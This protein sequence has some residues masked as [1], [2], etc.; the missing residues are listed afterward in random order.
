MPGEDYRLLENMHGQLLGQW[1]RE[2]GHVANVVGGVELINLYY[3]DAD[4]R[5]FML[6]ADYQRR[7]VAFLLENAFSTPE[8]MMPNDVVLR[9]T[10]DGAA[11]RMLAAQSGLLRQLVNARRI[12]RMAEHAERGGESPYLPAQMLADLREGLF[13]E[14]AGDAIEIDLYRRNLQ[15]TYVEHLGGLLD[16]PAANSDLPA[17]ARAELL[18]IR[19]LLDDRAGDANDDAVVAHVVDLSAR[20]DAALDPQAR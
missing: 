2:M 4:Q 9:L 19:S 20:I 18:R 13:S 3:G 15:R 11:D 1:R 7:A 8:A 10:R 16:E 12:N 14:L 17:L 5:F 6:D